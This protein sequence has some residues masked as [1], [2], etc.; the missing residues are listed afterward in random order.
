MV[1]HR[2]L[3]SITL[4]C[5]SQ[6]EKACVIPTAVNIH[7]RCTAKVEKAAIDRVTGFYTDLGDTVTSR[8]PDNLGWDLETASGIRI[9]VKGRSANVFDAELTPNE[10]RAFHNAMDDKAL[11]STY[12]LA[13]VADAL[14]PSGGDLSI[15]KFDDGRWRC[16]ITERFLGFIERPGARV[17]LAE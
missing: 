6:P 5:V 14:N 9:E 16:E 13:I 11:G 8:E 1:Y 2:P 7:F 15:F 4:N 3:W 10:Y 17:G 12:R